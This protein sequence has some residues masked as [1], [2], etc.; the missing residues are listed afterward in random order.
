MTVAINEDELKLVL[1][2]LDSAKLELL[3]L[4]AMLVPQ[5]EVTDEEKKRFLKPKRK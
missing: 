3:S 5:D 1:E 2:R 4:R